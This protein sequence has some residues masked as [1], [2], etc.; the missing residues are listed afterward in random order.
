MTRKRL[1]VALAAAAGL[2]AGTLVVAN[3]ANAGP[4]SETISGNFVDV[5]VDTNS[6][7]FTGNY[8]S[9]AA[10]GSGGPTYEGIVEVNF[11]ATGLCDSGQVEGKVI[12]YSIVRRYSN[13]DLLY[14]RLV[15]GFLCFTPG[16][17]TTLTIN[18]EFFGGTG[19]YT[20]ASGSYTVEFQINGLLPDGGGGLAHAAFFGTTKGT[21]N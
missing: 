2:F 5:A 15:D 9:G 1:L 6:N 21:I 8:F 16:G 14:S 17:A 10:K 19:R 4:L 7:G 3:T 18:A 20:G 12:A 13:G 11:E